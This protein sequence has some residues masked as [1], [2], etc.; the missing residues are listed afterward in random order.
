MEQL[1]A[2]LNLFSFLRAV[3]FMVYVKQ[4]IV[5]CMN[6]ICPDVGFSPGG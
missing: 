1:V 2:E 6:E 3:I 4:N 5:F